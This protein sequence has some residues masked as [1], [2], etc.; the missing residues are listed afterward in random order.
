MKKR[1][2]GKLEVTP[3]GMGC[4]ALS[5][6]YGQIPTE[7]Y[8]IEAI[9]KA[10]DAGCTFYDTAEIYGAQ[11]YYIGHNEQIVGK[12]LEDVRENVILA[13]KLFVSPEEYKHNSRYSFRHSHSNAVHTCSRSCFT[14]HSTLPYPVRSTPQVIT[15]CFA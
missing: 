10:Y 1:M 6:G 8:S 4:M 7:E 15:R 3:V 14:P 13:S 11:L 2:L 12:A 5:H 9:R